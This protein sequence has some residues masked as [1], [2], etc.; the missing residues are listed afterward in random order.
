MLRLRD[1]TSLLES[2]TDSNIRAHVA[3]LETAYMTPLFLKKACLPMVDKLLALDH[4]WIFA[5]PVDPVKLNIPDYF[6][7]IKHPMDL[8]TVK[9]KLD[10]HRY[11]VLDEIA[12]DVTL[13]FDNAMLYNP[14]GHFVHNL[15]KD[16]RSNF[17]KDYERLKHDVLKEQLRQQI[18]GEACGVCGKCFV[19]GVGSLLLSCP[20]LS[21]R[22]KLHLARPAYFCNGACE[23]KAIR[24]NADFWT[25]G[26][27]RFHWCQRC[28][29]QLQG[30][31]V[32][33]NSTVLRKADLIKKRNNEEPEES[34]V[35]C[36]Q[37]KYW[38]HQICG[39]YCSEDRESEVKYF[40]P[41]CTLARRQEGLVPTPAEP[42]LAAVRLR[43]TELSE[44]LE[45][46]IRTVLEA[47]PWE[48]ATGESE[49]P[50]SAGN[51]PIYVREVRTF[52]PLKG[53]TCLMFLP[54]S[55][56]LGP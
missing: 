28:Y 36:D 13:T 35:Q 1:A 27:D 53:S 54:W 9:D 11:L 37:C 16:M 48:R 30:P 22:A 46:R 44:V 45:R 52:V 33:V 23:N 10:G 38:V 43:H 14:P 15:A 39:L 51:C 19:P 56:T 29:E 4:A 18:S 32:V 3:S 41:N 49:V 12:A 21:G 50:G 25:E 17:L 5:E 31:I 34:W 8:G 55:D 26:A 2:L 42:G 47:G 20:V 6:S 7:V 40:C 24:V